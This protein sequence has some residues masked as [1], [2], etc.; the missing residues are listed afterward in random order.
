MRFGTRFL[1][2]LAGTS[3]CTCICDSTRGKKPFCLKMRFD[4]FQQGLGLTSPLEGS[5]LP[6]VSLHMTWTSL[7]GQDNGKC[8]A[9]LFHATERVQVKIMH[10][11]NSRAMMEGK[12]NAQ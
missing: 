2:G 11:A 6:T 10:V 12:G 3:I 4:S 1:V 5:L 9:F 7:Q 8:H